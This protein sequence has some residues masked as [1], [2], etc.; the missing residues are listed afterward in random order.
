VEIDVASGG[1]S[2]FVLGGHPD[3]AVNESAERVAVALNSQ[4]YRM[5]RTRV[6]VNLA[7]AEIRKEGPSFDLPIVL[8]IWHP[9]V[10][11]TVRRSGPRAACELV[12]AEPALGFA[13]PQRSQPASASEPDRTSV[14][15]SAGNGFF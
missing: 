3:A 2:K 14:S 4:G 8:G 13:V 15:P 10:G 9:A 12:G 1:L 7:P 6:L 11:I 5:P